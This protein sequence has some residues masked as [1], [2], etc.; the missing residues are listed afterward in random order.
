MIAV[1]TYNLE[2]RP[3]RVLADLRERRA[4]QQP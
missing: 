2:R 1:D 4:N 3:L